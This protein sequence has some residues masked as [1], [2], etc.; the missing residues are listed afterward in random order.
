MHRARSPP[1]I[2]KHNFRRHCFPYNSH[3]SYIRALGHM[4]AH[5]RHSPGRTCKQNG[6]GRHRMNRRHGYRK[7]LPAYRNQMQIDKCSNHQIIT[8]RLLN[9]T[10][11]SIVLMNNKRV[12]RRNIIY[13]AASRLFYKPTQIIVQW[14]KLLYFRKLTSKQDTSLGWQINPFPS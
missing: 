3:C 7:F 8:K 1:N 2:R 4:F 12:Q 9:A 5:R 10:P 14:T 6:Q 13:I 11:A